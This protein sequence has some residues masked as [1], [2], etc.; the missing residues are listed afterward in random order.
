M[1]GA[2]SP[3]GRAIREALAGNPKVQAW[4]VRGVRRTGIQTYL[5][6]TQAETERRVENEVYEVIV[7]VKNGDLVGRATAT[8][9]AGDEPRLA[10]RID[11]AVFMAGLGGDAPWELPK[12]EAWPRVELFDAALAGDRAR[13]TSRGLVEAW[14]ATVTGRAAVRPSSMELYCLEESTTLENS[15]GLVAN[16]SA[17]RVS[18]LTLLL[19][20]GDHASE[21]ETWEE[22]RRASDL[23]VRAITTQV[24]EEALDLTRAVPPP[25]GNYPVVIDAHE[26]IA[27]LAPIQVHASAESLYQKASR[28]EPGKPLPIEAKGGEPFTLI[29][30]A[31]A[32][33]G[34]TSYAFDANGV[35]GRRIEIVKDGVL[36]QPWATKQFADYLHTAPTGGFANW[37]LPA[38]KTPLEELLA[39]GE[40][41]LRVRNFSWLTPEVGRGNF[42]SEVRI[43]WLYEKGK[44]TPV[45]GGS[46][47]GNVFAALGTAH[48]SKET[49]F[50]GDY[51][52]PAAVRFE[53]LSV[54][55]L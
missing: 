42:G 17:T 22:R 41:V 33:F 9:T 3:L 25:S 32:P 20:S 31:V 15:A 14:R 23:D 5:V 30:N 37:E 43:G 4:Q 38:G 24:A 48:Y 28:F 53:G 45:K 39:S 8:L 29:S 18:L 21:R 16:D 46:V 55:G 12:A 34:L 10:R 47:S 50:R 26:I 49:V 19:A 44:R 40:R 36:V 52:G 51:L 11:E 6:Q 35:A 7:F 13:A 54:T 27:L 2:A 1:S